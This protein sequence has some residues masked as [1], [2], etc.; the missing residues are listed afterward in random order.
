M[1]VFKDTLNGFDGYSDRGQLLFEVTTA[2][3][4]GRLL[5]IPHTSGAIPMHDLEEIVR[6]AEVTKRIQHDNHSL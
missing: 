6:Y 3:D 4:T 2:L 1:T 5:F